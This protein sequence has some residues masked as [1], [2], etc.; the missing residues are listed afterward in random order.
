MKGRALSV[1]GEGREAANGLLYQKG[2]A[3]S[4]AERRSGGR[5]DCEP[6]DQATPEAFVITGVFSHLYQNISFVL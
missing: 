2:K 4:L 3:G 5:W 1:N 6:L